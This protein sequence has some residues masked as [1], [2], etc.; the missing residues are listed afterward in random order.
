MLLQVVLV[1][2]HIETAF[3]KYTLSAT[4][5]MSMMSFVIVQRSHPGYLRSVV[6]NAE[7]TNVI[8][9]LKKVEPQRVCPRCEVAQTGLAVHC[10]ACDRC[11]VDF[12]GHSLLVNNC[13]SSNNRPQLLMFLIA[14]TSFF[15]MLAMISLFHFEKPTRA[16]D[17]ILN[18]IAQV[19]GPS[20]P[21]DLDGPY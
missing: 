12:D 5:L 14:L 9:L 10:E 1:F 19:Q 4:A 16:I 6:N 20:A 21:T 2:P 17:G 3:L 15:T 7:E 8:T 18:D 13:I 11:V